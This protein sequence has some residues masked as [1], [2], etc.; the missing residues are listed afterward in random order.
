MTDENGKVYTYTPYR[1]AFRLSDLFPEKLYTWKRIKGGKTIDSGQF[2]TY[3]TV[4]MVGFENIVNFRDLYVPGY[5]KAGKAYRGANADN[6]TV[7]S[8][9]HKKLK[10][11]GIT[12]ELNLRNGTKDPARKDL[13][14]TTYSYNISDYAQ[15]LTSVT[16][17]KS[18]VTAFAN[19]LAAGKA[20]Y[21][22]CFAGADRTG[23]FCYLM[24]ALCGVPL[25]ILEAHWELT[26]LSRWCN[27]KLWNYER[28]DYQG[29]LR[30]FVAQITKL[31]G[32]D[33]YTHSYRFLTEKCKVEKTVIDKIIANLKK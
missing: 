32:A 6:V 24:Q 3:G 28:D 13:F 7:D 25:G 17:L 1:G 31:Y 33:P 23:T 21:V 9:D 22:H 10:D 27:F 15:I 14:A 26:S 11:L 19:S 4:H 30:T 16:N 12:V 8:A 20:V 2:R 18:T 5:V 29:E